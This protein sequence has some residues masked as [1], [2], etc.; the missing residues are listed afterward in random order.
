MQHLSHYIEDP[1]F[2]EQKFHIMAADASKFIYIYIGKNPW[3]G[4]NMYIKEK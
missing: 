2:L 4:N 1:R 3:G